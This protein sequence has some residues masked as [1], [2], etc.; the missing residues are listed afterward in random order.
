MVTMG[1]MNVIVVV[2]N[3]L[4]LGF[5]GA[6]GDAWIEPPKIDRLASSRGG[7]SAEWIRMQESA[8]GNRLSAEE[9]ARPEPAQR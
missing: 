7:S 8:R 6:S 4:H 9:I 1:L 5:L 3:R 2:C